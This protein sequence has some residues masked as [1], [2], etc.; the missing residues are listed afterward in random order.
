MISKLLE[1]TN[2]PLPA[3]GSYITAW[4]EVPWAS[5]IILYM[6][7]D[8]AGYFL[9]EGSEDQSTISWSRT[10]SYTAGAHTTERWPRMT[11][12]IRARFVNGATAQTLFRFALWAFDLYR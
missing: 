3:N 11:R 1:Y 5:E 9:I 2:T 6:L 8:Q 10:T 7:A 4:Y 12:Y